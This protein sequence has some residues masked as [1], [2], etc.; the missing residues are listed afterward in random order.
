[1]N[2]PEQQSPEQQ[3]GSSRSMRLAVVGI[4]LVALLGVVAFVSRGHESPA[5]NGAHDRGA[6]QALANGVFTLWV[7]AMIVGALMLAYTMSIKKRDSTRA[8][9]RV[10][11]LL[12]SL[13]FFAG[14]VIALVFAYNHLGNRHQVQPQTPKINFG[15]TKGK[16]DNGKLKDLNNPHSPA[17][18]WPIAAGIFALILGV[19]L[20][21]LIASK[22]RRDKLVR[23]VTLHQELMSLLDDTLDD[24]RAES[25]PRRAV[26]AAYARMEKILGAH[27]YARRPSEAPGE[28]LSRVLVD[29]RITEE[30]T[31][32][33]TSLF[34]RAKF[35][36]HAIGPEAKEEA[37]DALVELREQLRVIDRFEDAPELHPT[38]IPGGAT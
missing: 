15:T 17:F 2:A 6:S 11:P 33:L 27:G 14:V 23:E 3:Q 12:M 34:E 8:D 5:G 19:S 25:D 35:S 13:L 16:K 20:T 36:E 26:I 30:A 7:I 22:R 31:S 21:A 29:L 28:Y 18:Q 9:F 4:V 24:L 1:M 38:E 10:K 32:K 37:I